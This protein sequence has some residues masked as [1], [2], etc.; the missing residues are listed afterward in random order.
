MLAG[1][2]S[3]SKL[4]T[5]HRSIKTQLLFIFSGFIQLGISSLGKRRLRFSALDSEDPL[6]LRL[7]R[8]T[9]CL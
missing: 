2:A 1:G 4:L 7:R 8:A 9:V 3:D 6:V 5:Y